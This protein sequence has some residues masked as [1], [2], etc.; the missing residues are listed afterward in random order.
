MTEQPFNTEL[1]VEAE[2]ARQARDGAVGVGEVGGVVKVEVVS[3]H[4]MSLAGQAHEPGATFQASEEAVRDA[5]ARGLVE[6]VEPKA[7]R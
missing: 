3:E 1:A 5:L 6:K 7:K 4:P 2:Q